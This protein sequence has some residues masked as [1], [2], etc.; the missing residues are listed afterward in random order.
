MPI[1]KYL[2]ELTTRKVRRTT[3]LVIRI[4]LT[5]EQVLTV[6]QV[7]DILLRWVE[8]RD[9]E[10]AIRDIMPPRKMKDHKMQ[11]I[12]GLR[13]APEEVVAINDDQSGDGALAATSAS[14]VEPEP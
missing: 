6:N 7:F 5:V 11:E 14:S 12:G 13:K 8:M 1:G 10:A 3:T 9:W 2:S 4:V